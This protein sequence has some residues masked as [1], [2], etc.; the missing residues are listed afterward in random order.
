MLLPTDVWDGLLTTQ[1]PMLPGVPVLAVPLMVAAPVVVTAQLL[2]EPQ[3]LLQVAVAE[4][5][6]VGY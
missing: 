3:L 1:S 2:A 6:Q 5:P 4:K